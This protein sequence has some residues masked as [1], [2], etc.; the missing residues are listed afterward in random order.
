M[1]AIIFYSVF[2]SI[3]PCTLQE[4]LKSTNR[5]LINHDEFECTKD[6]IVYQTYRIM[7]DRLQKIDTNICIISWIPIT[8]ST[9]AACTFIIPNLGFLLIMVK[10]TILANG[11]Q[12]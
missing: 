7:I 2:V 4:H 11:G 9:F 10:N 8:Q 3:P 1:A 6:P 5:I 12:A